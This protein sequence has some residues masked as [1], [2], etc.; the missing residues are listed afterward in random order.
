MSDLL[1][2]IEYWTSRCEATER[3]LAA[4]KEQRR[5][6]PV[7]E[8]LPDDNAEVLFYGHHNCITLG[9]YH[10]EKWYFDTGWEFD[11]GTVT[12]W[13]PLPEPPETESK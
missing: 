1:G 10:H 9:Y 3:E 5:W 7:G 2:Q 12:H 6:I 8:R 4:L 13:Q 11:L